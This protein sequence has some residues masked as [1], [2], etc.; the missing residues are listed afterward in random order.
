M[1]HCSNPPACRG[2]HRVRQRRAGGPSVEGPHPL[3]PSLGHGGVCLEPLRGS[4]IRL[5][6]PIQDGG[7]HFTLA[8]QRES[9][10]GKQAA[11]VGAFGAIAFARHGVDRGPA[12]VWAEHRIA[13]RQIL[14]V[15]PHVHRMRL[16]GEEN[17]RL[18]V[19][20][21]ALDLSQ[22]AL[23]AR[24]DQFEI[25]KAKLILLEHLQHETVAV[26]A[27]FDAVNRI[28]DRRAETPDVV[29]VL[30]T[31]LVGV[32]GN[33]QG[34]FRAQQVR[35]DDDHGAVGVVWRTI[36][37][38]GRHP[39]AEKDIDVVILQRCEGHGDREHRDVREVTDAAHQFRHQCGG[40]S[41]IGPPYIGEAH[42]LAARRIGGL[43]G[44]G[45][46]ERRQ[47][48]QQGGGAAHRSPNLRRP[49]GLRR[50]SG[51]RRDLTPA[52]SRRHD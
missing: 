43:I 29:E 20:V 15:E 21:G 26:V 3:Q 24:F 41:H 47:P 30:E 27:G 22:H 37:R 4:D 19:A 49:W 16:P 7:H 2:R 9:K 36:G 18:L 28:V 51:L 44:G 33:R 46:G 11:H 6:M 42:G 39:V 8:A 38:L 50:S 14:E 25:P 40:R 1:I 48:Q 10:V 13:A 31:G 23:F 52:P 35:S 32:G 12:I 45:G 34:V 5:L 17:H